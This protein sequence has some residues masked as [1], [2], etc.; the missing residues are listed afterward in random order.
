MVSAR[1]T[2]VG[3]PHRPLVDDTELDGPQIEIGPRVAWVLRTARACRGISQSSLR[4][5]MAAARAPIS[6]AKLSRIEGGSARS[7]RVI[8][9]YESE[10]G[11]RPG[12]LL[13][14]IDIMCR[15]FP[16]SPHDIDPL[17][18]PASLDELSD[19]AAV[20]AAGTP[21]GG[22]WLAWARAVATSR[23]VG[24]PLW[25]FEPWVRQLCS[26]LQRSVGHAFSIRYEALSV[27]RCGPYRD[28]VL[29]VGQ[30]FVNDPDAQ[31][32]YDVT[33][34]MAELSDAAVLT[35]CCELLDSP[36]LHTM[37]AGV[38]GLSNLVTLDQFSRAE[39]AQATEPLLRSYHRA[40]DDPIRHT[41]ASTALTV[42]PSWLR[43]QLAARVETPLVRPRRLQRFGRRDASNRAWVGVSNLAAGV[44][45][46]NGL[47]DVEMLTRLLFEALFE[48]RDTRSVTAWILLLS[49]PC[50]DDLMGRVFE[51]VFELPARERSL[52]L[53]RLG[54]ALS[55]VDP[56][57]PSDWLTTFDPADRRSIALLLAQAG[58][59]VPVAVL[60]DLLA[61]DPIHRR[62]TLL[63]AAHGSRN[64]LAAVADDPDRDPEVRRAAGWWLAQGGTV[65]D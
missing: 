5:Q 2:K 13:A 34:A 52:G 24:I 53:E 55:G 38:I 4:E 45:R 36:R 40:L 16:N 57:P 30:E 22:D 28:V 6:A 50:R 15:T 46:A 7:S 64:W 48:Y 12:Q 18:D 33:S 25:L 21:T 54:G 9:A 56:R 31:A 43:R 29:R 20:I 42:V 44:C 3:A 49:A 51:F 41:I 23:A 60:E 59:P 58:Q 17:D 11:L 27:L 10:L 19:L 47:G 35:W 26:E 63:A 62:L 1:G 14:P 8:G 32:I 61:G 37:H 65:R 39:W